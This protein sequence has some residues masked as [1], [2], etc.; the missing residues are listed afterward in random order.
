MSWDILGCIDPGNQTEMVAPLLHEDHRGSLYAI[1]DAMTVGSKM[2]QGLFSWENSEWL[3]HGRF[4][5]LAATWSENVRNVSVYLWVAPKVKAWLSREKMQRMMRPRLRNVVASARD[6]FL[7]WRPRVGGWLRLTVSSCFW[8]ICLPR[9]RWSGHGGQ[10]RNGHAMSCFLPHSTG[11]KEE[12]QRAGGKTPSKDHEGQSCW[13]ASG[14]K[15]LCILGSE[16]SGS[17][18]H[19]R[20]VSLVT[21]SEE[22]AENTEMSV[23]GHLTIMLGCYLSRVPGKMHGPWSARLLQG[24]GALALLGAALL[25]AAL[26]LFGGRT[27]Q[28]GGHNTVV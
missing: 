6:W 24:K 26:Q 25:A 10:D 7:F 9:R 20:P 13:V 5:G 21:C 15:W 8:Q 18:A 23:L 22:K 1:S 17:L 14:S 27:M 12:N 28:P 3:Q 19:L 11:A 16:K 2:F 4:H